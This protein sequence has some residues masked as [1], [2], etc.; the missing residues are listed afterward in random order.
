MSQV[1]EN[2]V[3]QVNETPDSS[4]TVDYQEC[5]CCF[6]SFNK[7]TRSK[8]VC[9]DDR[10]KYATCKECVRT[11]LLSTTETP[12]CMKC[13][14]SWNERFLV[15]NL[16]ATYINNDYKKHRKLLLLERQISMLP[17]TM[18][19][20]ERAKRIREYEILHTEIQKSIQTHK[21]QISLLNEQLNKAYREAHYGQVEEKE[22]QQFILPCPDDS[23]RGFLS[24]AYKCGVCNYYACPKCLV[25]TGKERT[26]QTHVCDEELVKTANLIRSSTKPCPKC[27]ERIMKGPGCDQMWCVKCHTAFSWRTGKIDTGMVHNPH[28]TEYQRATNNGAAARNPNDIVCGGLPNNWWQI[29]NI[30]RDV[31]VGPKMQHTEKE[32]ACSA[33]AKEN[34]TVEKPSHIGEKEHNV[35]ERQYHMDLISKFNELYQFMRHVNAYDLPRLRREIQ[36]LNDS[37]Q[38]RVNYL[39]ND[40]TKEQMSMTLMK[41]DKKRRKTTE[42]MHLYEL[43]AAVG[44][45]LI[46]H[47]SD[48][49]KNKYHD[50][51]HKILC[52]ELTTKFEGF[53]NFIEY[54]NNQFKI[55]SVTYSQKVIQVR[56]DYTVTNMKFKLSD[57]ET[58][59]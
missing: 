10:C 59:V 11:Y 22:K 30:L 6:D 12:H 53:N 34:Y 17:E 50:T 14:T 35:C 48:F 44:N 33:Y 58:F 49:I 51:F 1:P 16:N 57:I 7:S 39:L 37:E 5:Q 43:L 45:D 40:I 24:T 27:G 54:L 36:Q 47:I 31:L 2:I 52:Q 23:C 13:K 46:N 42:T 9:P 25:L 18:P 4:E 19:A 32:C 26:D 21:V 55:I 28:F 29:R 38:L 15:S 8:V 56:N 3:I 20:L 41:R